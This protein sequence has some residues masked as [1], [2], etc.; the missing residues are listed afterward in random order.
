MLDNCRYVEHNNPIQ[1]GFKGFILN[2]KGNVIAYIKLCGGIT[3][4]IER[5]DYYV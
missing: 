2:E 1:A 3:T 4:Q 5:Y